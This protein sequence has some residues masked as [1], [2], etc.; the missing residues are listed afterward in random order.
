VKS[1]VVNSR[2]ANATKSPGA[3]FFRAAADPKERA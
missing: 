1:V 2:P 3:A